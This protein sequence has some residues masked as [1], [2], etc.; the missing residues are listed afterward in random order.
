[1]TPRI[2]TFGV[3]CATSS[4]DLRQTVCMS[5]PQEH[6]GLRHVVAEWRGWMTGRSP[7]RSTA[8]DAE[9]TLALFVAGLRLGLVAQMAPSLWQGIDASPRPTL[10]VVCWFST[11]TLSGTT[12]IWCLVRRRPPGPRWITLDVLTTVVIVLAGTLVVQHSER[13]GTWVGYFPGHM[14]AVLLTAGV[15]PSFRG[16]FA[17]LLALV[18][19]VVVYLAPTAAG[20]GMPGIISNVV[21]FVVVAAVTR[22]AA[23]AILR[24]AAAADASRLRAAELA[25]QDELRRARGAFHNGVAVMR[26]LAESESTHQPARDDLRRL[27]RG[28]VRRM[29]AYLRSEPEPETDRGERGLTHTLARVCQTFGDLNVELVTDLA[30]SVQLLPGE[31]AALET[32]VTSL[33][34]NVRQHAQ[35]ESVVVHAD[36]TAEGWV[37]TVHDDG[38]GFDARRAPFGVGLRDAVMGTLERRGLTARVESDLGFGTM[39]SISSGAR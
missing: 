4:R 29:R 6:G 36:V 19:S 37:V 32:A 8:R 10:Y 22:V 35:A 39:V 18:T 24:I 14:V 31:T 23:Q 15:L 34:L 7:G 33:L 17:A 30:R 3:T 9:M 38:V 25:R 26:M 28:E 1:V 20:D 11:V 13:V 16:W 2:R 27:A 21:T 5:T 12:A